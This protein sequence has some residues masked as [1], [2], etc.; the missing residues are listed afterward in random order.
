MVSIFLYVLVKLKNCPI[1]EN[2]TIYNL[3]RGPGVLQNQVNF[4]S[5]FNLRHGTKG[6]FFNVENVAYM[7]LRTLLYIDNRHVVIKPVMFG[8]VYF[9][10]I[11][12]SILRYKASS[13]RPNVYVLF[14]TKYA[15]TLPNHSEHSLPV[16]MCFILFQV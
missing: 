5:T 9:M 14:T 7:I 3:L 11:S 12:F 8:E 2:V 13:E 15:V 6:V 10:H 16:S 1:R 4:Q